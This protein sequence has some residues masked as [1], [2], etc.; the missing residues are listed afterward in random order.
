M[1][2]RDHDTYTRKSRAQPKVDRY[3]WEAVIREINM[4]KG[5]MFPLSWRV[6]SVGAR[7]LKKD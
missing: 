1:F 6:A 3:F 5:V 7:N 4:I 2:I